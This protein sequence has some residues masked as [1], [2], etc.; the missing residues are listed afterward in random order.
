MRFITT[1]HQSGK[2][3]LSVADSPAET[4]HFARTPGM[5]AARVWSTSVA[6][7][8][9]A[10]EAASPNQRVGFLPRKGETAF[11]LLTFPPDATF[12][13]REFDA[14][15]SG[16]EFAELVPEMASLR[17]ADDPGMHRTE[18]I[19]HVI[20]LDGEVWLEV[21]NQEQVL[22]QRHDVVIQNGTRHAW[23]NRSDQPV[24]MAVFMIGAERLA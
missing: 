24:T 18:T 10:D 22:L 13:A 14:A 12:S 5:W 11:R 2:A 19:D 8:V 15:A 7:S 1:F 3:K 23:R 4:I 9:G 6:P 21:D 17:E 20:I 16:A